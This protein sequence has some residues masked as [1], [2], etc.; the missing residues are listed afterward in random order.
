MSLRSKEQ[1]FTLIE[2]LIAVSIFAM[3]GF[4]SSLVLQN[5]LKNKESTNTYTERLH[6]IYR[7][8]G[9]IEQD[10]TQIVNR[11]LN[12]NGVVTKKIMDFQAGGMQSS[13]D[14]LEFTRLGWLNPQGILPRSELQRVQYRLQDNK[15]ERA[16]YVYPDAIEGQEPVVTILF[17]EVEQLR[18]RFYRNNQWL[19]TY[20]GIKMPKA[21]VIEVVFTDG[22]RFERKFLTSHAQIATAAASSTKVSG[23]KK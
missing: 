15:L 10:F 4:A 18:F 17:E 5:V 20:G 9:A 11:K 16:H 1:G 12:N 6:R 19:N 13:G 22:M 14:S 8:M 21:V 23:G 2:M 3:L 7:G